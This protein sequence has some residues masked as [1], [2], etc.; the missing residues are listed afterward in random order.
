MVTNNNM[1]MVGMARYVWEQSHWTKRNGKAVVVVYGRNVDNPTELRRFGVTGFTPYFYAKDGGQGEYI[2]C[3]GDRIKKVEVDLPSDVPLLRGRYEQTFEADIVFDMRYVI[4]KKIYYGFDEKMQPV[5]VPMLMPRVCWLD[6]EVASPQGI[7]PSVDDP[8]YPVTIIQVG[9]SYT[10]E[11]KVFTNGGTQVDPDQVVC[12]TEEELFSGFVEYVQA[13]DFDIITGWYSMGFDIPYLVRRASRQGIN[14]QKVS[15]WSTQPTD[16]K[17]TGRTLIDY[18][19]YYKDWSK[20]SG[21]RQSYDLKYVVKYETTKAAESAIEH[22]EEPE[23]IMEY[24]DY[25]DQIGSLIEKGDWVTAVTYA[26][27][28]IKALMRI[29]K[30]C[31]I[32]AF[33]ENLRRLV[34]IKFED[35]LTRSKIIEYYLMHEGIKPIPTRQHRTDVHDYAGAL[36]LEPTPGV[37]ED[38]GVLDTKSMYPGIIIAFQISPDID[39]MIPKTIV[40]LMA[41]RDEMRRVKLDGK[42]GSQMKVSEQS[43]KY[44]INSFYGYLAFTGARLYKPEL[45]AMITRYGREIAEEVHKQIRLAG[46]HVEYGDTDAGLASPI[47][48][49]EE[50]LQLQEVLNKALR[51][52]AKDHGIEEHLAP[53]LKFEKL[54]RRMLFKKSSDGDGGAAKKRYAGI[55]VW[56]DGHTVDG[57]LDVTGMEIRRSD[58]APITKRCMESFLYNVLSGGDPREATNDVAETFRKIRQG[59]VSLQEVAI[60]KGIHSMENYASPWVRGM[61]NGH[62]LL[63][64]NYRQDKKPK[65]LYCRRPYDVVCIDDTIPDIDVLAKFDIDWNKMANTIIRK[66]LESLIESIGL[67]WDQMI[68]NQQTISKWFPSQG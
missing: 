18:M 38:V 2:S 7:M 61:R 59:R 13:H 43:L 37:K 54:Y 5:D 17:W 21:Q 63:G 52:W 9:D 41:V 3:Y 4:D 28:D 44:I 14:I 57:K 19:V 65:L 67:D 55:L 40:K 1:E 29:D 24:Q 36:V 22:G 39:K 47:K 8:K 11:I 27:N 58:T 33:Y 68:N 66:K 46:Y 60:P 31:G 34:G 15:R 50:G 49:A 12:A 48:T 64:I 25:G 53:S 42:A 35:T 6:I 26:K 45:A 32:I 56:K 16:E 51:V 20:P 10:E 30:C 62:E 23:P